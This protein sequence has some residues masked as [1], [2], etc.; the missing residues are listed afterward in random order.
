M[1]AAAVTVFPEFSFRSEI[2]VRILFRP[3]AAVCKGAKEPERGP[4]L[5]AEGVHGN[6]RRRE[7]EMRPSGAGGMA[8]GAPKG[9]KNSGNFKIETKS[10]SD[11]KHFVYFIRDSSSRIF[12][13]KDRD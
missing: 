5:C 10:H 11:D 4:R 6:R 1:A 12:I 2:Q 3:P 8:R 9:K 13:Q 7:A